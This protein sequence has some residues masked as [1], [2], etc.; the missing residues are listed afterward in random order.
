MQYNPTAAGQQQQQQLCL[1]EQ[2]ACSQQF[3]HGASAGCVI[4][5]VWR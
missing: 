2:A 3:L 1:V 4:A 5:L